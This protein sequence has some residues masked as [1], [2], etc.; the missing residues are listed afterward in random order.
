MRPEP[1]LADPSK[2]PVQ[3]E[4]IHALGQ[5]LDQLLRRMR[6]SH[7]DIER[8]LQR[9]LDSCTEAKLEPR[10]PA[11]ARNLAHD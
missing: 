8:R 10:A 5:R 4:Q 3:R 7:Q 1:N 2:R 11:A 6:R 9:T